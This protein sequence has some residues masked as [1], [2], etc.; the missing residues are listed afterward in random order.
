M[1]QSLDI[2][3]GPDSTQVRKN[4]RNLGSKYNVDNLELDH[5]ADACPRT[6]V[7]EMLKM[8]EFVNYT[9][10]Q[11]IADMKE[12]KRTDVLDYLRRK[13]LIGDY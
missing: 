5:L 7:Q 3:L 8:S 2:C 1:M 6:K 10:D 11:L 9:L 13:N 4:W 12:F